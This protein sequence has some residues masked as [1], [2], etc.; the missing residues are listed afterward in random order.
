MIQEREIQTDVEDAGADDAP[1]GLCDDVGHGAGYR[2]VASD[3]H[4]DGDGRVHVAPAYVVQSLRV[5][6]S[7][8]APIGSQKVC[9]TDI[10]ESRI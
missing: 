9:G 1:D 6:G 4:A 3:Q 10:A 8:V 5:A 2:H 7:H